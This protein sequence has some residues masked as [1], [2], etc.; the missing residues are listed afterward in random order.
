MRRGPDLQ[1]RRRLH[2]RAVRQRSLRVTVRSLPFPLLLA[3][4]VT[5]QSLPLVDASIDAPGAADDAAM[6]L[7]SPHDAAMKDAGPPP[8]PSVR[9]L[10]TTADPGPG[11]I[12]QN[13]TQWNW[14]HSLAADDK[15]GLHAVWVQLGT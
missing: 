13:L 8:V 6:D 2:E 1:Y 12:R 4:C 3:G 15:S 14:S 7:G 5:A 10:T 11:T 9:R